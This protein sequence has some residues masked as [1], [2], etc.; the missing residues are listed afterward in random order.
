MYQTEFYNEYSGDIIEPNVW[1]ALL[2]TTKSQYFVQLYFSLHTVV[3]T[4]DYY[5]IVVNNK[6][7]KK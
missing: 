1:L 2:N 5:S 4:V 6:K 3:H 7:Y